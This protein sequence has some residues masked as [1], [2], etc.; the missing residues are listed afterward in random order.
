MPAIH[1]D[2][3][4]L[5]DSE[6]LR[7]RKDELAHIISERIDRGRPIIVEGVLVLDALNE[8]GRRAD[9]LIFVRGQG[10]YG[11]STQISDY[12]SRQQPEGK[13]HFRLQG[14]DV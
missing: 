4:L 14:F 12:N 11:L 10:G 9:F 13:A 6:H 1:L 3:Y 5:G 7:W 2:L 8:V